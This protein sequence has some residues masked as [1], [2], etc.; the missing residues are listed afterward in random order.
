MKH[1]P[2]TTIASMNRRSF[3]FSTSIPAA[4]VLMGGIPQGHS[5]PVD[6][7]GTFKPLIQRDHLPD[8]VVIESLFDSEVRVIPLVD[9][10]GRCVALAWPRG[11]H[12]AIA[13]RRI[14]R[15]DP[16]LVVAEIG[17]NHNGDLDL[18]FRL[19]DECVAAGADC[20]KF[21]MRD[22]STLYANAAGALDAPTTTELGNRPD[23]S[24]G[25]NPSLQPE[26]TW[27]ARRQVLA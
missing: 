5:K 18:A 26:R 24:P 16:C 8:P 6:P 3:L 13:G 4:T 25:F 20:I 2:L 10:G 21:Q 14:G 12:F 27:G 9:D 11:E 23:G 22:L 19:I 1:L 17:N 7:I 15:S